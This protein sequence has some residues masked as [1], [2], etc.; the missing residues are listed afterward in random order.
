MEYREAG[1]TA[2]LPFLLDAA[3]NFKTLSSGPL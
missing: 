2:L 1:R 3:E